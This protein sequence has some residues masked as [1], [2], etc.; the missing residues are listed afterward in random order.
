MTAGRNIFE[1]RFHQLTAALEFLN[2]LLEVSGELIDLRAAVAELAG[3]GVEGAD[4]EAEFVLR[5]LRDL[6]LEI[7]GGNLARAF[8]EGLNGN[9]DLF[10]EKKRDPSNGEEQQQGEEKEQQKH[11]ALEG[12]QILF[13]RIVFASLRLDFCDARI[14]SGAGA[15]GSDERAGLRIRSG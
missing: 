14:K 5:L 11:L 1:D 4:Q 7:A 13:L 10:R 2:S 8:S 3:H 9:G 12:A 15:V 6:I